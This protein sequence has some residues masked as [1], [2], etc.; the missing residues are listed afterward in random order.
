M[1]NT[2]CCASHGRGMFSIDL[3]IRQQASLVLT[4]DSAGNLIAFNAQTGA[5]VSS[6][7]TPSSQVTAAPLVDGTAVYCGYAQSSK[8]VKFADVRNLGAAPAWQIVLTGAVNA[9][10][11]LV[12]GLYPGDADL[13]YVVTA[14]G[15]LYVLDAATG[16]TVW[17]LQVVTATGPTVV[18]SN[19]M[20]NQW[21][22]VATDKGL[23]AV[24]TQT[25]SV[26]WR[27]E[28]MVCSAAPLLAANTV[29]APTQGGILYSLQARTG[30]AN[31]QND[32]G[33]PNLPTPVWILGSVI[34]GSQGGVKGIDY[35]TG[36]DQFSSS[37]AMAVQ[38]IAADGK[39]FWV[40]TSPNKFLAACQ[41]NIDG[42]V[43]SVTQGW[44]AETDSPVTSAPQIVG[45]SLYVTTMGSKLL[46]CNGTTMNQLWTQDLP[47]VA[48][49]G[50]SLV[51]G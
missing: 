40:A 7:V 49:G 20:M 22:Y 48:R 11:C 44:T 14:D 28:S 33:L 5:R 31:W 39:Q 9:T 17:A 29:F 18:Y 25:R 30:V 34:T 23:Y 10:P 37:F 8:V 36:T 42:S 24:N 21:I 2:L 45:T 47:G 50:P 1:G 13:L 43:R 38:A 3:T 19:Q 16:L 27:K 6:G 12:K 35:K 4:G 15:V 41:L 32:T 46:A 26:G 51:Y